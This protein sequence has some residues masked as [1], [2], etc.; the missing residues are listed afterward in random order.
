MEQKDSNNQGSAT[1]SQASQP[2]FSWQ[3]WL[4]AV[5]IVV[6]VAGAVYFW[7]HNK[8]VSL[9]KQLNGSSGR[10]SAYR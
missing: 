7:Q 10:R 9:Q 2:R 8:V 3:L 1:V 6:V 5:I 4:V